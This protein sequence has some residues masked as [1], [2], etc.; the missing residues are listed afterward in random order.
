MHGKVYRLDKPFWEG[1]RY[2]LRTNTDCPQNQGVVSWDY[3]FLPRGKPK[4]Q[5]VG[6]NKISIIMSG[7]ANVANGL[8]TGGGAQFWVYLSPQN[9][10]KDRVKGWSVTFSQG[11]WS[12]TIDANNP[13]QTL[14]TPGL[15]GTFDIKI[16]QTDHSTNPPR[17]VPIPPQSGS[18]NQIGCNSNCASMVGIV[19]NASPNPGGANS[20]FWTTWDAVCSPK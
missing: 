8:Q 12:G 16:T 14:Q 20:Q 10:T 15:S 13:T 19:A 2:N 7:T 11:S 5:R 1:L 3:S 18:T 4:T 6:I 9:D 17:Q